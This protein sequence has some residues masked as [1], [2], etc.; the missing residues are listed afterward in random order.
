MRPR[1]AGYRSCCVECIIQRVHVRVR[2]G[3]AMDCVAFPS[4]FLECPRIRLGILDSTLGSI[5]TVEIYGSSPVAAIST[6][7][8]ALTLSAAM[9]QPP[10]CCVNGDRGQSIKWLDSASGSSVE[11]TWPDCSAARL[12]AKVPDR[13]ATTRRLPPC[14]C[15]DP[16]GAS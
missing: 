16:R 12:R 9:P 6:W 5:D 4:V 3:S 7:W 15:R 13:G 14:R 11:Q 1:F 10:R 8:F 2:F